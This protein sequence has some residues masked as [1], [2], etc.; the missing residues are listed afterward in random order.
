M[1]HVKAGV[2]AGFLG[3]L[4]DIVIHKIGLFTIKTTTTSQYLAVLMFPAKDVNAFRYVI[5]FCAHLMAGAIT[6]V[7]LVHVIKVC[8]RTHL[9]FKSI[10]F[11]IFMWIIHVIIIPNIINSPRPIIFRTE[12]ESIVDFQA[13]L[14][15]SVIAAYY[16]ARVELD[17][18]PI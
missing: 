17:N 2:I 18:K 6:G 14:A 8:G 4:G 16:L 9:Y 12:L 3:T 1:D 10:S 5:G 7:L 11:G 15:F 13:H